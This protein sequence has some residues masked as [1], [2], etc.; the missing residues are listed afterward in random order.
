MVWSSRDALG[1]LQ[2][3]ADSHDLLAISQKEAKVLVDWSR[4]VSLGNDVS[5]IS[6]LQMGNLRSLCG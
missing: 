1:K 6:W 5:A 3:K 4:S 2:V